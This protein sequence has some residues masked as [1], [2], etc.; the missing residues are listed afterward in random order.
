MGG[1]ACVLFGGS[2]FSRDTDIAILPERENINNLEAALAEL[3]AEQIAVP[4]LSIEYLL[5]G[6]AVHFRCKH[7]D[8][9]NMRVD[10][11]SVLHNAPP[12][13][14]LWERRTTI[15]LDHG[16]AVDIVS[17]SDLV[18]I[19]KTQRDKDWSHIRRL[20]EANYQENR[21]KSSPE[22]IRFWLTQA[23]TPEI[24]RLL[25]SENPDLVNELKKQ[26]KLL[27]LLPDGTNDEL[28]AA[29]IE[30]EK[31]EREADR[32]YWKPLLEELEEI[33]HKK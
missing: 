28:C 23:R 29:L 1:Q 5:K 2:E 33:R 3:K 4:Q 12:F 14:T 9:M 16:L 10:I 27:D 24:L 19:K 31:K 8:A 32:V 18:E 22:H 15:E 6:H 7:P 20:V 26:R 21:E 17:L 13:E 30:E 25:A 11:M